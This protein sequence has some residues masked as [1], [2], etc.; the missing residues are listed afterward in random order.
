MTSRDDLC[1]LFQ[2]TTAL[3]SSEHRRG[4]LLRTAEDRFA[5]SHLLTGLASFDA[6][7]LVMAIFTFG[8][9]ELSRE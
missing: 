6:L 1:G 2:P 7:F 3:R 5:F 9:K 8:L 4:G